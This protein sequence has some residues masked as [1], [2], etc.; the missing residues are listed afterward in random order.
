[1]MSE[2]FHLLDSVLHLS[3]CAHACVM[4][5]SEGNFGE[6]F[7]RFH[8]YVGSGASTLLTRLAQ[9]AHNW[10]SFSPAHDAQF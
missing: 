5:G 8:L 2:D 6:S 9:A 7:L 10:L 3:V 1:M 4:W